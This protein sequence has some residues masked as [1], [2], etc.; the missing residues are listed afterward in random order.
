MREEII[1]PSVPSSDPRCLVEGS[2][3]DRH[4]L[5]PHCLREARRA[6]PSGGSMYARR[7]AGAAAQDQ[8]PVGR[9]A[10]SR[11]TVVDPRG[12]RSD[13]VCSSHSGILPS[14]ELPVTPENCLTFS[15][16]RKPAISSLNLR[17]IFIPRRLLKVLPGLFAM[18]AG[19]EGR[20]APGEGRCAR[21]GHGQNGLLGLVIYGCL[22]I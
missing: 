6:L 1:R 17:L 19:G 2:R 10:A 16:L 9:A 8:L 3:G 11:Q 4:A 22:P 12:E 18:F 15:S 7:S 20:K 5:A 21:H 13:L 14:S